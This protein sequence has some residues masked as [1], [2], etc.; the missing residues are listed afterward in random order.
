ML[1]NGKLRFRGGEKDKAKMRLVKVAAE[2]VETYKK[3]QIV[4]RCGYKAIEKHVYEKRFPGRIKAKGLKVATQFL[5]G[6]DREV[7]LIRKLPE[8]EWDVDA[9]FISG[10]KHSGTVDDGSAVVTEKQLET[11]FNSLAASTMAGAASSSGNAEKQAE[12]E[13]SDCEAARCSSGDDGSCSDD[14][15]SDD[16]LQ[17]VR[18]VFA[19]SSST[20]VPPLKLPPATP[21]RSQKGKAQEHTP[22]RSPDSQKGKAQEQTP[23]R[24]PDFQKGKSSLDLS[25][26]RR[27][28]TRRDNAR[29]RPSAFAKKGVRVVLGEHGY[30]KLCE[31]AAQG[32][33]ILDRKLFA[34][35]NSFTTPEFTH[36][37]ADLKNHA[38]IGCKHAAALKTK[39][40]RWSQVPQ[41]AFDWTQSERDKVDATYQLAT[42]FAVKRKGGGVPD[43]MRSTLAMMVTAGMPEPLACRAMYLQECALDLARLRRAQELCDIFTNEIGIGDVLKVSDADARRFV[44]DVTSAV[45]DTLVSFAPKVEKHVG[46]QEFLDTTKSVAQTVFR[47]EWDHEHEMDELEDLFNFM[48]ASQESSTP[49][50][51]IEACDNIKKR[52]ED[53]RYRGCLKEAFI[54]DNWTHVFGWLQARATNSSALLAH[55]LK[56]RFEA[57]GASMAGKDE[58]L[59]FLAKLAEVIDAARNATDA[60]VCLKALQKIVDGVGH[61]GQAALEELGKI[62]QAACEGQDVAKALA[63]ADQCCCSSVFDADELARQCSHDGNKLLQEAA[64]LQDALAALAE[65]AKQCKLAKLMLGKIA[66]ASEDKA[67]DNLAKRLSLVERFAEINSQLKHMMPQLAEG[68]GWAIRDFQK[69]FSLEETCANVFTERMAEFKSLVARLSIQFCAGSENPDDI[70]QSAKAARDA[71]H[72]M[73]QACEWSPTPSFDLAC[74]SFASSVVRVCEAPADLVAAARSEEV[75]DAFKEVDDR[76]ACTAKAIRLLGDSSAADMF[77]SRA[78]ELKAQL[79]PLAQSIDDDLNAAWR[80]ASACLEELLVDE[81]KKKLPAKDFS[82]EFTKAKIREFGQ[83][84]LEAKAAFDALPPSAAKGADCNMILERAKWQTLKWGLGRFL[85]H[86]Q[87]QFETEAGV[88]LRTQLK[89]IWELNVSDQK[90]ME[91]LSEDDKKAVKGLLDMDKKR[92]QQAQSDGDANMDIEPSAAPKRRRSSKAKAATSPASSKNV[93][94]G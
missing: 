85:S 32:A 33:E 46:A 49:M 66:A 67:S 64:H 10:A 84:R 52:V 29:G 57:L 42:H 35:V 87:I 25:P 56:Q 43:M 53:Q 77:F 37:L 44:K 73:R 23:K 61:R 88:R 83:K 11:K 31:A 80:S 8:G 47:S 41:E 14:D 94:R 3:Q 22:K 19:A 6:K 7:V 62:I 70:R 17:F 36:A 12:A 58:R 50:D 5:E 54:N 59:A 91:Y 78:A 4:G 1:E 76:E 72:K 27:E 51:A 38:A 18:Q 71:E 81:S 68:V 45:V 15:E 60:S 55:S 13:M 63:D 65:T 90:Y 16:S 40:S 79:E 92:K 39:L 21:K 9:E 30:D 75:R 2:A 24:S 20:P 93:K 74:V 82:Q 28:Y 69:G 86:Q 34:D 48:N 26:G 89:S